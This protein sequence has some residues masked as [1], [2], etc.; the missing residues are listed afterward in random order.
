MFRQ[1]DF[2]RASAFPAIFQFPHNRSFRKVLPNQATRTPK[3][4]AGEV[5]AAADLEGLAAVGDSCSTVACTGVQPIAVQPAANG[6][7]KGGAQPTRIPAAR[8]EANNA[9]CILITSSSFRA[10]DRGTSRQ[11][12]SPR[13]SAGRW[14]TPFPPTGS[15]CPLG[16]HLP[17]ERPDPLILK[18]DR[19]GIG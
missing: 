7:P 2:A 9:L 1:L 14:A 8:T 19:S 3:S 4:P 16:R 5:F 11:R 12:S 13:P 18:E 17:D 15:G 10:D 6:G